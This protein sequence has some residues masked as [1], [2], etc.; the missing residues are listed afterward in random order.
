MISPRFSVVICTYDRYD[1]LALAIESARGQDLA[2][3]L[4][5][6]W[7][8]DNTPPGEARSQ[9]RARWEG[10]ERLHYV[11][12]DTPGLSNARNLAA[13]KSN[14][15]WLVFLD[16][17]A[18]AEPGWLTAYREATDR[19]GAA[20]GAGGGKVAVDSD[21]PKPPWLHNDLLV[22]LSAFNQGD[23]LIELPPFLTPA[24]ANM[25]VRRELLIES[26]GFNPN[27][28]RNG[29][30]AKSLLSGEESSFFQFLHAKGKKVFYAP[31][32]RVKHYVAPGR[33]RP[34]WFRRRVAWQSVTDQAYCNPTPQEVLGMWAAL[35]NYLKKIPPEHVP[36]AG[37]FWNTDD[38][39]LFREQIR[40]V[41][42]FTHLLIGEG[43][44]PPEMGI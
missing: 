20:A 21:A 28:G 6:I 27:L 17:D 37:L 34:E 32:A 5:D 7:V 38:P 13:Q 9:S 1:R 10:V 31:G 24:G 19:F 42:Y 33:L 12:V 41:Q 43:R 8:I 29:P 44:Y 26:G 25:A 2:P 15:E 40:C 23:A 22:Y 14:A 30:E 11:E 16:D 35:I 4:Y 36:Y 39:E 18:V 3:E